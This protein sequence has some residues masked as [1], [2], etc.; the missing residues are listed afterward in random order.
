MVPTRT[1]GSVDRAH[2]IRWRLLTVTLAALLLGGPAPAP[3]QWLTHQGAVHTQIEENDLLV[4]TDRHYTQGVKFSFLHADGVMP[5]SLAALA[6]AFPRWGMSE[7][8]PAKFGYQLGQSIFTPADL[9]ATQLLT[10]DRPYAGWLYTG[11][12]LQRRGTIGRSQWPVLDN[13]QI[14][15]GIIGP[16]SLAEETQ[17]AVHEFRGFATPRGWR[18][19]LHDEPGLAVKYQRS[20]LFSPTLREAR[21]VDLIP[22]AG[23]SLGNVETSFRVGA[24][25]RLGVN[26]P[27]DFGVS[28]I[29]SLATTEGGWSAEHTGSRYG[30]YVFTAGEA[31]T[32][33]YT[34]FLDGNLFRRS[35][36]VD[37]IPFVAER[38]AGIVFVLDRVELA[39]TYV[40]R[41][42]QFDGQREDDGYGSISLKVKF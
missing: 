27:T 21:V 36:R 1:K 32:V 14:D 25:L 8:G 37:K 7:D 23:V 18:N 6:R 31:W 17:T 5:D 38:K 30:F 9:T 13:F 42:P 16:H 10:D 4:N 34:A 40:Y 29:S 24:M 35:H 41:T 28:T 26:L 19:Q 22:H 39:V 11:W 15:V 20:W 33:L 2:A 3:A 12:I